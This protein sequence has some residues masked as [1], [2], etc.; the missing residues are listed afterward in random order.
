MIKIR[1][2]KQ[3]YWL[4]PKNKLRWTLTDLIMREP[5]EVYN[6]SRDPLESCVT[7][8]PNHLVPIN[9]QTHALKDTFLK[10]SKDKI[11][12]SN[13]QVETKDAKEQN[14]YYEFD[15]TTFFNTPPEELKR[16]LVNHKVIICDFEDGLGGRDINDNGTWLQY[17]MS[18]RVMPREIICLT[19]NITKFEHKQLNI[20]SVPLPIWMHITIDSTG[21]LIHAYNN[22]T[23]KQNYLDML[24]RDKNFALCP[25]FKPRA[26]RLAFIAE[27]YKRNLLD[28]MDWSLVGYN[29]NLMNPFT[30]GNETYWDFYKNKTNPDTWKLD[31]QVNRLPGNNNDSFNQVNEKYIE[32]YYETVH[33]FL[34]KVKLP[35]LLPT[36]EEHPTN[37]IS[38]S[39]HLVG[40]YYWHI[41]NET[42]LDQKVALIRYGIITEKTFKAMIAGAMPLICGTNGTDDYLE[43]LGFKIHRTDIDDYSNIGKSLRLADIYQEIYERQQLPNK[44]D[45][46]HN[47]ELLLDKEFVCSTIIQP[48]MDNCN[49]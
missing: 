19:S 48:L 20:K 2:V 44:E 21:F 6:D 36:T 30:K 23:A 8:Y 7:Q 11:D 15:L 25:N 45:I 22:N 32:Y 9:L 28:T 24:D 13:E 35:K 1:T 3:H 27:M 14:T 4:D 42:M 37:I 10:L 18:L 5:A 31:M 29:Q 17:I 43:D 33:N 12:F 49:G 16:I 47:A 41:I 46:M 38:I 26:P 34:S 39:E 40:K